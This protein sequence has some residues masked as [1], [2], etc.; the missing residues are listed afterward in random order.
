MK[1]GCTVAVAVAFIAGFGTST[2]AVAACHPR[3]PT[4][5]TADA[6]PTATAAA[7]PQAASPLQLKRFMKLGPARR[8]VADPDQR[9]VTRKSPA[10]KAAEPVRA[11]TPRVAATASPAASAAPLTPKAIPTLSISAPAVALATEGR[12]VGFAAATEPWTGE[13]AFASADEH[14]TLPPGVLIARSDEVN[15]IDRAADSEANSG[16]S[17]AKADRLAG[18]SLLTA[19]YAAGPAQEPAITPA[20]PKQADARVNETSWLSWLYSK[21]LDGILTAALAL[22]AI[23]V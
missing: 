11:A 2:A 20:T 22:R 7:H 19:A 17:S 9:R 12:T 14:P 8:S 1:R 3:N 21:L 10:E 6:Q 5:C 23:F 15:D 4:A 18:L 16:A 13:G